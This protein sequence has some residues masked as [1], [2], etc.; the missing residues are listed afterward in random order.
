MGRTTHVI[1]LLLA[2]FWLPAGQGGCAPDPGPDRDV[3]SG[4]VLEIRAG[5]TVAVDGWS[6]TDRIVGGRRVWMSTETAIDDSMVEDAEATIDSQGRP[7][8]LVTLDAEGTARLRDLTTRR[9]SRPVV[10][11]VDGDP[12]SAPMVLSPLSKKFLV[13]A[14]ELDEAEAKDFAARLRDAGSQ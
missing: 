7:A 1:L 12:V 10:V 11:V 6:K 14:E 2:G 9:T 13:T 8:V 3:I 5:D 4:S